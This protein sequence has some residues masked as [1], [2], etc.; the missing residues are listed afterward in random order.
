MAEL[1]SCDKDTL[2]V[3]TICPAAFTEKLSHN[4]HKVFKH[5]GYTYLYQQ[6]AALT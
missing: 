5:L 3:W 6:E 1:S 4:W 2:Q